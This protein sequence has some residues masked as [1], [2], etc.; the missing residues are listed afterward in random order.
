MS[1]DAF[2]VHA[3]Y[4]YRNRSIDPLVHE[5]GREASCTVTVFHHSKL[6]IYE[7]NESDVTSNISPLD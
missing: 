7:F 5:N 6:S 3:N 4:V 1:L 2:S